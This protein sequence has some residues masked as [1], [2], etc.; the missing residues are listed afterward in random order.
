LSQIAVAVSLPED[1]LPRPPSWRIGRDDFLAADVAGR[2]AAL[3]A[4]EHT[5]GYWVL[6]QGSMA[7]GSQRQLLA[8]LDSAV[9]L[10][11]ALSQH[12]QQAQAPLALT[13]QRLPLQQRA[14]VLFSRHPR[15]PDLDHIVVELADSDGGSE[16]IIFHG[17][18]Q[19][20][21]CSDPAAAEP[22][23]VQALA[24]LALQLNRLMAEPR[25]VEWVW[26]GSKLWLIQMMSIGSL[27]MPKDAWTRHSPASAT[28]VISPLW[29]TLFG[30]WMK[31][32]F[33]R[34]LGRRAG[35]QALSNIEPFRRQHSHLYLN[36]LFPAAIL[37]WRSRQRR[38]A[39]LPPAWRQADLPE[40]PP[41]SLWQKG[42][43][44]WRLRLLARRL[45]RTLQQPAAD[46]WLQL[47]ALD[48]LGEKLAALHGQL[49]LIWLPEQGNYCPGLSASQVALLQGLAQPPPSAEHLGRHY[50]QMAAGL[51]PV[52]PRWTE[53]P[54]DL[55]SLLQGLVAL[56][57]ERLAA[58]AAVS[59]DRQPLSLLQQ[60]RDQV[61]GRLAAALR[62]L[63][64]DMA[65]QLYADGW[66]NHPDDVFFLYFDELWQCW[67]GAAR[68]G[69]K[70]KLAERKV[71]Y[72]TDAH[73]GPPDWVIDQVG[74]GSSAFARE[75]RQPLL[76]G[77]PLVTGQASGPL[78]RLGS[79]WQLNQLCAG[80]ILVL[81]RCDPGWLP[82]LCLAAGLV[83]THRDPLDPA[84][85]LAQALQ[86]PAVW[87]VDDAMHSV[88]DGD[89]IH[90]DGGQGEVAGA[91]PVSSGTGE[92]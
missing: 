70:Q 26:D 77:Y 29:Y 30:R 9:A 84:V 91:G 39:D 33:W 23:L 38:M 1:G 11:A 71:R 25:A 44:H 81:D 72:L 86:I 15:R 74:Y 22:A 68:A 13:V 2:V 20:A 45:D 14:G 53:Q 55:S 35:W 76:R 37:R 19:L 51:D 47:M 42:L 43:F 6:H 46:P 7:P 4:L 10:Q 87:G 57:P 69:L 58:M 89:L 62:D 61:A 21:W 3:Q 36:S 41:L 80:D 18:G 49:A 34:P 82:W 17:D 85:I 48:L 12:F 73:S 64:R 52:W 63:L 31:A 24:A 5:P 40:A 78:R 66:L 90:L 92:G 88:V 54:A 65:Q 28:Q 50:S 75:N 79:G 8:N 59:A 32:G 56:P 27:P 67:R 16:R 83:L 60:K